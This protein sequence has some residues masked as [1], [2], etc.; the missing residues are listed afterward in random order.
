MTKG[1]VTTELALDS[2]ATADQDALEV[3]AP[4][5]LSVQRPRIPF[6]EPASH[7]RTRHR[8]I[9]IALGGAAL[10]A[11][12]GIVGTGALY[13]HSGLPGLPGTRDVAGRIDPNDEDTGGAPR[14]TANRSESPRTAASSKPNSVSPPGPGTTATP[15]PPS[16]ESSARSGNAPT[17]SDAAS[18]TA[19]TSPSPSASSSD[20]HDGGDGTLRQ[21]DSGAAVTEMQRKLWRLGFHDGHHYGVFDSYTADSV[22]KFQKW[23]P[24]QGDPLGVYG[25]NTRQALDTWMART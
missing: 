4:P 20:D 8:W 23:A 14:S 13:G 2:R 17:P 9:P 16:A 24:V 22:A 10:L 25:P 1:L 3:T 6:P 21:G 15:R 12:V 5:S 7:R 11:A 19:R 18:P